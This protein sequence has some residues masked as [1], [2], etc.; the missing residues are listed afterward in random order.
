MNMFLSGALRAILVLATAALLPAFADTVVISDNYQ[1]GG[2]GDSITTGFIINE[3]VDRHQP[4]Y[5]QTHG[6]HKGRS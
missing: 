4:T 3:G 5:D 6:H 1:L 2:T